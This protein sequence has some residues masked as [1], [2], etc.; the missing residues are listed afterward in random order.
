MTLVYEVVILPILP[1]KH[2]RMTIYINKIDLSNTLK[3][4]RSKTPMLEEHD[5]CLLKKK[6]KGSNLCKDKVRIVK[7]CI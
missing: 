6:V 4:A 3:S 2:I 5:T 7:V 1:P